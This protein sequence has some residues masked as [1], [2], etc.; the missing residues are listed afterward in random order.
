MLKVKPSR[1]K[2]LPVTFTLFR[3]IT[4]EYTI[5]KIVTAP[6]TISAGAVKAQPIRASRFLF[7]SGRPT[8]FGSAT[9]CR[10]YRETARSWVL[11]RRGRDGNRVSV[12]ESSTAA[13]RDKNE[14]KKRR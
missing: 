3:L 13:G 2:P 6:M 9:I 11:H 10:R 8:S 1:L 5:G 14:D 7:T 12:H 4:I